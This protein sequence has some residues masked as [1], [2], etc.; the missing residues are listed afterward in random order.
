[1]NVGHPLSL[2]F[3]GRRLHLEIY[4]QTCGRMK[5]ILQAVINHWQCRLWKA[6]LDSA[7]L[8]K[9]KYPAQTMSMFYGSCFFDPL[10]VFR[11][12]P[13]PYESGLD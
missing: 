8:N 10:S 13:D 2:N 6:H 5:G 9:R 7:C 12:R 4:A 11:A 1:M 3:T